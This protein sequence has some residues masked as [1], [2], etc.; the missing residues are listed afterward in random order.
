MSWS[1]FPFVPGISMAGRSTP[2]L[3]ALPSLANHFPVSGP[4]C[5]DRPFQQ[6][7]V[8][9]VIS[10]PTLTI[11]PKDQMDQM[12]HRDHR[13]HLS[14][15]YDLGSASVGADCTWSWSEYPHSMAHPL[16][17]GENKAGDNQ[18]PSESIPRVPAGIRQMMAQFALASGRSESDL[19]VEAADIWLSSHTCDDEPLPPA[20]AAALAV[21]ANI[22]SWEMIDDLLATLRTPIRLEVEN[23]SC[24]A[25]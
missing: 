13:D 25:A 18:V 20:P 9:H 16:P 22:R 8:S 12:S 23:E 4:S 2:S 10:P 5:R 21:P 1:A 19:W 24:K 11:R 14:H 6:V 7:L 17:D 15:R 3:C